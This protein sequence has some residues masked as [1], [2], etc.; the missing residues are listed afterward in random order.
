MNYWKSILKMP[1]TNDPN[2]HTQ[3]YNLKDSVWKEAGGRHEIETEFRRNELG[4]VNSYSIMSD[5]FRFAELDDIEEI[6]GRKLI[7][8]DFS[9]A[10]I[11]WRYEKDYI[12]DRIGEEGRKQLAYNYAISDFSE[13]K[14]IDLA[15]EIMG[16]ELW[17][18][19][20]KEEYE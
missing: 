14:G 7:I 13:S 3:R 2:E 8:D 9:A 5:G 16:P 15:K 10:P 1:V 12:I 4:G 17:E 20:E 11:N 18:K 19:Y 6:L